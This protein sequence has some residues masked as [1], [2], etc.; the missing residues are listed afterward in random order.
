MI[1]PPRRIAGGLDAK[2]HRRP[3][4]DDA[5]DCE[6]NGDME[7]RHARLERLGRELGLSRNQIAVII[8]RHS[9]RFAELIRSEIAET[10]VDRSNL[11][12]ELRRLLDAIAA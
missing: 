9:R 7:R 10:L 5:L 6:R 3:K 1:D 4:R 8:H 11:D 12:L 2:S